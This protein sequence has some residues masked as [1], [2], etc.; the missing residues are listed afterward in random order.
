MAKS[1]T[2]RDGDAQKRF[3][4]VKVLLSL[5]DP[6]RGEPTVHSLDRHPQDGMGKLEHL[7]K[8]FLDS[9]ALI[10]S[11]SK[12][13]SETAAA[14]CLETGNPPGTVLR[15]ARNVAVP[16]TEIQR[17]EDVLQNLTSV[18]NDREYYSQLSGL[19]Y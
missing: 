8:K 12:E 13:G 9:F 6:V 11:T 19:I 10:C 1:K 5:I 3:I 17:L 7:Q 15:I 4:T 16:Q 14:V 18:A 2:Q